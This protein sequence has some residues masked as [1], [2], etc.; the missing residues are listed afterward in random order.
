MKHYFCFSF[1]TGPFFL[2]KWFLSAK[3]DKSLLRKQVSYRDHSHITKKEDSRT[4]R[5]T[6][7]HLR[8]KISGFHGGDYEECRLLGYK[9]QVRTW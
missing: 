2:D 4:T 7:Q 3:Q 9:N 1:A 6:K 5:K 8:C